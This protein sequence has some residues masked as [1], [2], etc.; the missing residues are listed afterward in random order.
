[1]KNI[2]LLLCI[3]VLWTYGIAQNNQIRGIVKLQNSGSKPLANVQISAFGSGSVYSNSSGMYELTFNGKRPGASVSIMVQ[4]DGYELINGRELERCVIRQN[5]DDLVFI[6]MAKQGQRNKQALAYYNIIVDNTNA[7]YRKELKDINTRLAT[8]GQDDKERDVLLEQIGTLQEEKEKLITQA[9]TL[10]KQLA[11]VDLDQASNLA[12][13]AYEKFKDGDVKAALV[14]LDDTTLDNNFKEAKAE[15]GRL[16]EKLVKADSAFR[17]S[18]ENY[19]IK[20]R[21]CISDGQYAAA[22]KNYLKAVE[23]DSTNIENVLE[24]AAYCDKITQQKRAIKY[25]Q[26]ALDLA[27]TPATKAEI[28]ISLGVQYTYEDDFEKVEALY[29]QATQIIEPL[30][31]E[32][33]ETF[34]YFQ[35]RVNEEQARMQ[36]DLN[37]FAKAKMHAT[38]ALE[39]Y[40]DLANKNPERYEKELAELLLVQAGIFQDLNDPDKAEETGFRALEIFSRLAEKDAFY[41]SSLAVTHRLIGVVYARQKNFS[42]AEYHF[43]EAYNIF[44]ILAKKN[45]LQYKQ[46]LASIQGSI[47]T[48]LSNFSS[49]LPRAEEALLQSLDILQQ[50]ATENPVRFESM[51]ARTHFNLAR[52]Y[53]LKKEFQKAE[54]SYLNVI[55]IRRTLTKRTPRRYAP[56]LCSTILNLVFLKKNMAAEELDLKYKEEALEWLSKA[57]EVLTNIDPEM[58]Q[59]QRLQGDINYFETYFTNLTREDLLVQQEINKCVPFEEKTQVESDIQLIV[60]AQ[61]EIVKILEPALAN[62]PGHA[63]LR[64]YAAE[65]YG[66]LS[67][68]YVYGGEFK[69]A[70]QAANRGLEIDGGI[71][72]I[73]SYLAPALLFQG[74][75]KK[76]EKIYLELKDLPDGDSTFKVVLLN[77]LQALE[78]QGFTHNDLTKIKKRLQE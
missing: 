47:G 4:L 53:V 33:P 6:I 34:S 75:Y 17:Q 11:T 5:P 78:E 61:E 48:M 32:Q 76:A 10:A 39:A 56:V 45:P 2:L 31:K 37:D 22:Y 43:E 20:A 42:K 58:P 57:K 62:Y 52:I 65:A 35:A 41:R 19:M 9:E 44:S 29:E 63:Q 60:S 15:I 28:V 3:T 71:V 23:A 7:N 27:T 30:R 68:Y 25:Y 18:I 8:L 13:E 49:E 21:F 38:Q 40:S 70:E 50:L 77:N 67:W 26:Q 1:M 36:Q 46:N 14:V 74:K 54:A 72:W 51:L 66:N 73:K 64:T 69:K 59:F 12:K 55:D 16:E 24:L